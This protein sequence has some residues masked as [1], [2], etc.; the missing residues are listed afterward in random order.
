VI[1]GRAG[2]P[3]GVQPHRISDF[4]VIGLRIYDFDVIGQHIFD[5]L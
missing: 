4:D 2:A 5:A 3:S 1:G